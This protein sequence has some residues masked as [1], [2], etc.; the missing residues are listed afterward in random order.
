MNTWRGLSGR[1]YSPYVFQTEES[2]EHAAA[3]V[4]SVRKASLP[5]EE[6]IQIYDILGIRWR[7]AYG[8]KKSQM[9]S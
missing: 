8:T 4:G 9:K 3:A 6:Q 1:Q 2:K 7:N 5:D